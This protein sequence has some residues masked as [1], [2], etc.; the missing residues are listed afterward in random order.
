MG[1]ADRPRPSHPRGVA[2]AVDVA[3]S[4]RPGPVVIALS[5]E[6]QK[7]T[8]WKSRIFPGCQVSVAH[9]DPAALRKMREMIAA[10]KTPIAV[11]GGSCWTEAGRAAIGSFLVENDIPVT[12]GFRRQAHYDGAQENF[13][14]DVGVGSGSGSARE[15]ARKRI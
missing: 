13:A 9:P 10:A 4:G 6:M 14:G 11:V 3:V 8:A 5:E 12:V 15:G 7:D 2:H 1:D